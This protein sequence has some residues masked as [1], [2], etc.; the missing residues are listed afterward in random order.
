MKNSI[1]IALATTLT[2]VIG[3]GGI[4]AVAFAQNLENQQ[5]TERLQS[6]AKITLE[7][8]QQ[9][10]ESAVGGTANSVEL[11]TE[12]GSLVYEVEIGQ[13]EVY[14]DAGNGTVLYTENE[15]DEDEISEASRPQGS[16]QVPD[17]DD[18]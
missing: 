2:A 11:E 6:L 10:A 18:D 5:E 17:S 14:I 1:K 13:T 12:D 7:E 16:I 9:A 15:D 8:A 4:A 3:A